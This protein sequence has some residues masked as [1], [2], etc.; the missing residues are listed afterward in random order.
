MI[1]ILLSHT[2]GQGEDVQAA[3]AAAATGD[4]DGG[5]APPRLDVNS[6]GRNGFT[7]L[8]LAVRSANMVAVEALLAGGADPTAAAANS[9]SALEVA[10]I[11]KRAAIIELFEQH[12]SVQVDVQ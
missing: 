12:A 10:R 11:N 7:A 4:G 5:G 2:L 1:H 9:K 6:P 8:A 3:T